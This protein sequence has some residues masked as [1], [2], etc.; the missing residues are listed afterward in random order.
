MAAEVLEAPAPATTGGAPL[1]HHI[2]EKNEHGRLKDRAVCGELWDRAEPTPGA[3]I[4]DLCR[5]ELERRGQGHL[6]RHIGHGK[7]WPRG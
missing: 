1:K 4:C 6:I 5:A 3:P 7:G 2:V